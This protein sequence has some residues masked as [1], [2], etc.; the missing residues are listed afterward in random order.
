MLVSWHHGRIAK[1]ARRIGGIDIGCPDEWPDDRFDVVWIL[2]RKAHRRGGLSAGAAM[3]AARRRRILAR[4]FPEPV[5]GGVPEGGDLPVLFQV[6][7]AGAG[8]PVMLFGQGVQHLL[9][10]RF[11]QP[12]GFLGQPA[13]AIITALMLRHPV[14]PRFS[15]P[16]P[17]MGRAER[18]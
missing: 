5:D 11:G 10:C 15:R 8:D 14:M 3:P 12:L 17:I 2:E 9:P 4:E 13:P 16:H 7:Q 1:L 6:E 18:P